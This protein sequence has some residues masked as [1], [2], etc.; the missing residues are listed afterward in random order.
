[1]SASFVFPINST[2]FDNTG[3]PRGKDGLRGY[4]SS[5]SDLTH[6]SWH[7]VAHFGQAE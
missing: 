1:M 7:R 4:A 2:S 5:R 6:G 3:L